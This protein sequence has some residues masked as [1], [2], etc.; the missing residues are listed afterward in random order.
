MGGGA[1]GSNIVGV[2]LL[3][4]WNRGNANEPGDVAE[5]PEKSSLFFVKDIIRGMGSFEDTKKVPVE[6]R[7]SGG[8]R[9]VFG[10]RGKSESGFC[11]SRF[12]PYQLFSV[13]ERLY[14]LVYILSLMA[15]M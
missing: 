13:D 7:G 9:C 8:V 11:I 3:I 12:G 15:S 10:D 5:N 14:T 1:A 4:Q 2:S 6:C